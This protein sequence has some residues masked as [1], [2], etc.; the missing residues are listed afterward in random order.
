M[1]YDPNK[2]CI[3]CSQR[4]HSSN[5]CPRVKTMPRK[6]AG[7]VDWAA[8]A[9]AGVCGI[10]FTSVLVMA[11]CGPVVNS[12][13]YLGEWAGRPVYAKLDAQGGVVITYSSK[14]MPCPNDPHPDCTYTPVYVDL[15]K[16][17]K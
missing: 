9:V 10:L 11:R 7:R 3:K 6:Q 16:V 5:N 4:G 13:T 1:T 14:P 15:T 8:I 17:P 12:P 2:W